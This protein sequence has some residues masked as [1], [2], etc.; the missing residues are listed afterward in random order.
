MHKYFR[1]R[2]DSLGLAKPVQEFVLDEM[3]APHRHYHTL[4]HLALMLEV[5]DEAHEKSM[6]TGADY[7]T[8][9]IATLFHDIVYDPLAADNEELSAAE[10]VLRL[11]HPRFDIR[12]IASIIN[13][14][15][16]HD[17]SNYTQNRYDPHYWVNFA[18]LS[19]LWTDDPNRY[20]WYMNGVRKEFAHVPAPLYREGRTKVLT[21]LRDDLLAV[22]GGEYIWLVGGHPKHYLTD[23]IAWELKELE[24]GRLDDA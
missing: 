3:T 13:S 19:I 2:M 16:T 15:K 9:Q 24:Q 8:A 7:K 6:L 10:A 5:L 18:D 21:K 11:P 12:Q 1:N 20:R 4:G 22:F 14:T 23:N 17:L